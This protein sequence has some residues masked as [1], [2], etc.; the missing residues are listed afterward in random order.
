MIRVVM[1]G[2]LP[3]AIGGMATVIGDLAQSSLADR[4]RL[5]LF[6]TGKQT[7]DGRAWWQGIQARLSLMMRWWHRL[8]GA[9]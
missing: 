2:P 6:D 1:T 8:G 5:E 3:P 4:V 9:D 7:A